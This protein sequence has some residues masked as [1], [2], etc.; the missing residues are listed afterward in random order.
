MKN[1]ND[2]VILHLTQQFYSDYPLS[3]YPQILRKDERPYTVFTVKID[4]L[5]FAIPFRSHIKHN[6]AFITDNRNPED[7]CGLDYTKA[8]II[9]NQKY[10][11]YQSQPRLRS[12]EHNVLKGNE[13][14]IIGGFKSY[15]NRY[16]RAAKRPDVERNK[17]FCR[18]S[19]LQYFHKEL[20][21]EV[22]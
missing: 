14:K 8:V 15:L 19:A 16:K 17:Q 11:D 21:I 10:I 12:H 3:D 1:F 4:G 20:K 22:S 18:F 5:D 13:S 7:K 2:L 6:H 9:T